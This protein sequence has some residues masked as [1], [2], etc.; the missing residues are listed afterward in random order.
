MAL[1]LS[2]FAKAFL[3]EALEHVATMESLLVSINPRAPSE[4]SLNALFRSVHSI[5]GGAGAFG[6]TA[7][8][9]FTHEFETI[10]D[11]VRKRRIELSEPLIDIFLKA[12]DV[13]RAHIVALD[14]DRRPDLGALQAMKAAL[15]GAVEETPAAPA[16]APAPAAPVATADES[17][18]LRL[19]V[20]L[21]LDAAQFPDADSVEAL[22]GD[23]AGLGSIESLEKE[24][25]PQGGGRIG[26][27][28]EAEA[29]EDEI[30]DSLEFLLPADAIRVTPLDAQ[31]VSAPAATAPA[32]E[33]DDSYGFFMPVGEAAD[34]EA[35]AAE[36][37]APAAP[38]ALEAEPVQ[39]ALTDANSIR[40]NVDKID[41]LVNLVGE[42]VITQAMVSQAAGEVAE[43]AQGDL[44]ST[45][46][47]LER[48]TRNLQEAVLAIRMLPISFVFSRLPRLT[49]DLAHKLAKDVDL[50]LQGEDTELDKGL[51]ERIADPLMHLV[52]NSI[53]HGME[54]SAERLALGKNAT[55]KLTV[56][57]RHEGGNVVIS[58]ADDGR[59]LDRRKI[60][61][62]AHDLGLDT[63]AEWAEDEVW[64]LIFRPGFSTAETVTE[65]SGRGVGMDVVRRNVQA[66]GGKIEIASVS[67]RGT[68]ITIRLPL[69]LAIIDGLSVR[70]D[71]ETY[72]IPLASIA[73]SL[74]PRPGDVKTVA[75]REVLGLKG[76]FIPII[77]F[78][79]LFG[80]MD[81]STGASGVLVLLDVDGRRVAL[82]VDDLLG[83]HQAVV[84]G[85]EDNYRKVPG[86]SG[87]TILGDGRVA[88]IVDAA[89]LVELASSRAAAAT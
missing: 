48:N 86:I 58:V 75:G 70:V 5:K 15:G 31:P 72:I 1:D 67:G 37:P 79:G 16:A 68:T 21:A 13:M 51:I 34:E 88:L 52:R 63:A 30:R 74:Q 3:E 71:G 59:G 24:I 54:P 45:I 36:S 35:P 12:G 38:G 43:E 8:T 10:L 47:Q 40:V 29:L 44:A 84:K 22:I 17:G 20:E 6:H 4:E 41:Q 19:R 87:A 27:V 50:Q 46:A 60:L 25:G 78:G 66:L 14:Q 18:P 55:G 33:E 57:A 23:L 85:L 53:D 61:A 7:L 26:F 11:R 77:T 73:Q 65:V 39:S 42:L 64:Q 56:R 28:V 76:E 32:Q 83:Q 82:R 49:R 2:R 69:T 9:D 80:R 81:A 89:R 62:K